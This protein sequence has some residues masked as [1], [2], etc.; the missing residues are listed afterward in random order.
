MAYII[1]L[2]I[3]Y[4]IYNPPSPSWKSYFYSAFDNDLSVASRGSSRSGRPNEINNK[5]L[6]KV[7]VQFAII[8][9]DAYPFTS[10]V[11]VIATGRFSRCSLRTRG[12]GAERRPLARGECGS[13][14]EI[15]RGKRAANRITAPR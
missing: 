13:L 4:L 3:I 5:H 9:E 11:K 1:Y 2:V 6:Q 15:K 10:D 7:H 14:H 12:N 8:I